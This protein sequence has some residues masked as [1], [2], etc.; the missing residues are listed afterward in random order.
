LA[1]NQNSQLAIEELKNLKVPLNAFHPEKD[2][3]AIFKSAMEAKAL[4][5]YTEATKLATIAAE[6]GS[7][8]ALE[9]LGHCH[10]QGYLLQ[11]YNKA[12]NFFIKAAEKGNA[13]AK[14]YLGLC[15]SSGQ[16][17]EMDETLASLFYDLASAQ[18]DQDAIKILQLLEQV[19][20]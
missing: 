2:P 4:G 11:D 3:K 12:F 10:Y 15:Y 17:V 6:G 1:A 20:S 18:N 14:E 13:S 8:D 7:A 9:Y 16:G 5:N 19:T